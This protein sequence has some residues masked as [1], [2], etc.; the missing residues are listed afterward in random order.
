LWFWRD[1]LAFEVAVRSSMSGEPLEQ[2][3]ACA[4]ARSTLRFPTCPVGTGSSWCSTTLWKIAGTSG[5]VRPTS[6]RSTSQLFDR[7]MHAVLPRVAAAGG[8]PPERRR[9]T[10]PEGPASDSQSST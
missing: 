10:V 2:I 1:A 8:K 9:Q 5:R 4:T 3:T 7:D 6:G